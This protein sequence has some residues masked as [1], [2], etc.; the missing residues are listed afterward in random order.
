MVV[1]I[2]AID[3]ATRAASGPGTRPWHALGCVYGPQTGVVTSAGPLGRA[4]ARR[5][6]VGTGVEFAAGD[7]GAQPRTV[8]RGA[9]RELLRVGRFGDTPRACTF[10]DGPAGRYS[11][12]Q[13]GNTPSYKDCPRR[14][15]DKNTPVAR[16]WFDRPLRSRVPT[17]VLIAICTVR[18]GEEK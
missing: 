12:R 17:T 11:P 13:V 9:V 16:G 5:R 10:P 7:H 8:P 1:R 6:D 14:L 2:F 4:L 18:R 3:K 15:R